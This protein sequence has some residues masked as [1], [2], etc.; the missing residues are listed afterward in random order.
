MSMFAVCCIKSHTLHF[1]Q[2]TCVACMQHINTKHGLHI[3]AAIHTTVFHEQMNTC[4]MG[5]SEQDLEDSMIQLSILLIFVPSPNLST[6]TCAWI[7]HF[8]E[9]LLSKSQQIVIVSVVMYQTLGRWM[10]HS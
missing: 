2:I 6:Y 4:L 10:F 7:L 9:E 3:L 1:C 8:V 5:E